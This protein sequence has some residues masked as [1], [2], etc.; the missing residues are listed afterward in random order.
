MSGW[1]TESCRLPH[2]YHFASNSSAPQRSW[3]TS[4]VATRRFPRPRHFR[5]ISDHRIGPDSPA[6]KPPPFR[7]RCSKT[8]GRSANKGIQTSGR[9]RIPVRPRYQG[10]IQPIR[11]ECR[12]RFCRS[13][14][15]RWSSSRIF[16][17]A[18]SRNGRRGWIGALRLRELQLAPSRPIA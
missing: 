10:E 14:G 3:A 4:Q 8:T 9:P 17:S 11:K 1:R 13:I 7:L 18:S 2:G 16:P 5:C 12:P 15:D 6:P